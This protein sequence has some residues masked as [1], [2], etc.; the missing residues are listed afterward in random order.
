MYAIVM[1][2]LKKLFEVQINGNN[3]SCRLVIP[4]EYADKTEE[5]TFEFLDVMPLKG[6]DLTRKFKNKEWIQGMVET[7]KKTL[8]VIVYMNIVLYA[9]VYV[10]IRHSYPRYLEPKSKNKNDMFQ[11]E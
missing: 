4:E 3:F 10:K 1:F 6:F 8:C 2:N 5:V 7:G 11:E 9:I